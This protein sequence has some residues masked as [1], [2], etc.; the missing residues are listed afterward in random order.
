LKLPVINQQINNSDLT[1][2][3]TSESVGVFNSNYS[4][5]TDNTPIPTNL[6]DFSR[7]GIASLRT[8]QDLVLVLKTM[9]VKGPLALTNNLDE[10]RE[11]GRGAQFVVYHNSVS[12]SGATA[13]WDIQDVAVKRCHFA[14]QARA[15]S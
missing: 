4:A 8:S 15:T 2:L 9:A 5:D 11:I 6:G 1:S 3:E 7:A 12:G 14:L 13:R 10:T